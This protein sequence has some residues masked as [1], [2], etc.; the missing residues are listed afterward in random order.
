M[1]NRRQ[2]LL[3]MLVS[4][5]APSL[6]S[7]GN[8]NNTAQVRVLSGSIPSQVLGAFKRELE[9]DQNLDL[10]PISQLEELYQILEKLTE[11][12]TSNRADLVTLGDFWLKTAIEKE[13][14]QPLDL[15]ALSNWEALPSPWRD[16]VKRD[17][18]GNPDSAGQIW[19][20]P[21]CWG[22]TIIAYREDK[23]QQAEYDPP[24]DW[25]DLWREELK[26]KISLL[27]Q[28]REVIGLTL[29]KLGQSYNTENLEA[30]SNLKSE[31]SALQKQVKFYSSDSYIQPLILGDTWLAV[32]WS[33]DVLD[34]RTRYPNIK[35]ITPQSGTA[36][37][38]DLWV[39]PAFSERFSELILEWINFC[40]KTETASQIG[41]FTSASS[42][43]L[44]N[45]NQEEIPEDLR[46]DQLR[47]P[48]AEILDQSEF[49]LP[50]SEATEEQYQT[51]WEKMRI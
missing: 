11:E 17:E 47:I 5:I 8:A 1:L 12:E 15:E 21:Y 38:A 30:V 13:L 48:P 23:F 7:C 16:L 42:P 14:I 41:L 39:R 36:M 4:A 10:N 45:G 18:Q 43:I 31:L 51:I 26:H 6:H 2:F 22:N 28:P 32:G 44:L 40:W 3:I 9:G 46:A 19:G 25:E 35:I 27:D 34:L 20:A 24:T 33:S 49:L 29:K 37:W 50:L